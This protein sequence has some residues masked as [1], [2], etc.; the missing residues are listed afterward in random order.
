M[1]LSLIKWIKNA[2]FQAIVL[3]KL[4]SDK[5]TTM[6]N[7]NAWKYVIHINQEIGTPF[8]VWKIVNKIKQK[9]WICQSVLET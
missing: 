1:P 5:E 4:L 7:L 6:K 9:T 8:H 3:D 2:L